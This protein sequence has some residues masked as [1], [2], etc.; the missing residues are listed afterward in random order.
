MRIGVLSDSHGDTDALRGLMDKMG[1]L[2]ALCFLGDVS[3]DARYIEQRLSLRSIKPAFYA[4]KG[5][6]DIYSAEP[7][8]MTVYLGEK[9]FLLVHGHR[10]RVKQ[11]LMG[12]SLRAREVQ[13]D[14][15]LFGHTHQACCTYDGDI[16]LLNPGSAGR[17]SW[18]SRLP[19]AAVVSVGK[20]GNIAVEKLEWNE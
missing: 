12:L 14:V 19:S 5:N 20:E 15:V 18:A 3:E 4:V 7:E 8:E 17:G 16:L 6:N 10:Q 11:G 2:D 1:R 9:K 13:A